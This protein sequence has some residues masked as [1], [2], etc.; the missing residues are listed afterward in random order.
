[1]NCP[2]CNSSNYQKSGTR[3]NKDVIVQRVRCIS[4]GYNWT[5]KGEQLKEI[6]ETKKEKT[7]QETDS[8]E[9]DDEYINV[10]CASRRV[11]TQEELIER[12]KI[13]M[14]QWKII[15][16]KVKTSEGYRK[17]RIVHWDVAEGKVNYGHVEDS[18]KMLVVPLYHLELKLARK[19]EE[20]R[21]AI[22]IQQMIKDA[23]NYAPKY[24]KMVYKKQE[25]KAMYEID[26]PD[27]HFGRLTWHEESGQDYDIKI[28]ETTVQKVLGD[29]LNYTKLFPIN[30][31][32]LPLGNDFF[33]VNTHTNTTVNGT[34]QQ[35]DTRWSKT[36]RR[37]LQL[38]VKMVE[39]C[40]QIAPV[41]ILIIKGNHDE[42]R[43]FYMGE[44]LNAWFHLNNNVT[45]DNRAIGKKYYLYGKTLLGF[46][47]GTTGTGQTRLDKYASLM[48]TEV[49][50]LWA[51]ST[52][53]EWHLGHIHHKFETMEEN[54][55]VVRFLRSLVPEDAWTYDSGYFGAVKAA[56]AFVWDYDKGLRAQFT[57][58]P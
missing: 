27:I 25:G 52:Y 22:V 41:D 46:A 17:D 21:T 49:P 34:P 31:I 53:R 4:C 38:A 30:K 28:A 8:F 19:T 44:Y 14:T 16:F 56:E 47:H 40:S 43:T 58:T 15:S 33:N 12:H 48:P 55:V 32:L 45:I 11:M 10:I 23:E 3:H 9:Q 26:M 57:A 29:L 2:K 42:E 7:I 35:E 39:M 24:P 50:H 6:K 13:D 54:G 18:G 37:G 20:I 1:M 36:Y 51:K 5:V